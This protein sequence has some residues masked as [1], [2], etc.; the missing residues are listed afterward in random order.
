MTIATDMVNEVAEP[1]RTLVICNQLNALL[2]WLQGRRVFG[3]TRR[4]HAQPGAAADGA[5]ARRL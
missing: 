1:S 2:S 5:I 4:N 3:G